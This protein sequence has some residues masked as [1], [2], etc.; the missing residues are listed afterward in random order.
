MGDAV[1]SPDESAGP[2]VALIRRALAERSA[3]PGTAPLVVAVDGRSGGGKST[4]A[5]AVVTALGSGSDPVVAVVIE[6]DDFY[7]GGSAAAWD[8]RSIEERAD[9]VI[10]WRRQREVLEALRR[11]EAASWHPFDW[12]S[13]DW[14]GDRVPVADQ[15]V[16]CAPGEAVIL[17]GV[18]S[19]RPELADLVDLRVLLDPPAERRGRQLREREG[20]GRRDDWDARWAGAEEHYFGVVLAGERCDLVLGG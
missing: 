10:D 19:A 12:Y 2:V 1:P 13:D 15:P 6:G 3:R 5:R 9:R 7:A 16:R 4:L 11:G 14:D 8:A 18:Y 17:E 20:E